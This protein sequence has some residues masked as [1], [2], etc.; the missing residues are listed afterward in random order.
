MFKAERFDVNRLFLRANDDTRDETILLARE[1][2]FKAARIHDKG[3]RIIDK[4][5]ERCAVRMPLIP[6]NVDE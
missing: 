1:V 5:N 3:P 6:R 4:A 2:V